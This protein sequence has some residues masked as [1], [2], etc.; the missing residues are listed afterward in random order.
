MSSA[1][2]NCPPWCEKNHEPA[3]RTSREQIA[4]EVC[5]A[6]GRKK[7]TQSEL[8]KHLRRSQPYVSLRLNGEVAFDTD[9]IEII[10][11]V[12]GQPFADFLVGLAEAA[13]AKGAPGAVLGCSA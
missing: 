1:T 5:A 10:S 12:C 2:S 9:E 4:S 8:A 13:V 7:I 3:E 11:R 6:M